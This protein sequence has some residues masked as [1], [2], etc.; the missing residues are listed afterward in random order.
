MSLLYPIMVVVLLSVGGF[1]M[2]NNKTLL[3]T[4]IH[5]DKLK[6]TD[7]IN[8]KKFYTQEISYANN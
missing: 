7:I 4:T 2:I 6:K 1:K 3:S 5:T 8:K